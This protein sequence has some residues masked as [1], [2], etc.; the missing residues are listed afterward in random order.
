MSTA[1]DE[2]CA[3][4]ERATE[5]T[6]YRIERTAEGFDLRIAVDDARWHGL[7]ASAGRR[8]VVE[9]QV[10]LDGD[11]RTLQITDAQ[12]HVRWAVGVTGRT[13]HLVAAQAG[14]VRGRTWS[15]SREWTWRPGQRPQAKPVV[16]DRLSTAE[17]R[18]LIRKA[19]IALGWTERMGPYERAGLIAVGVGLLTCLAV[20]LLLLIGR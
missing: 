14:A 17:A 12:F 18:R 19:A 7:L 11:A 15:T 13:P 6:P 1:A 20:A 8:R 16:E 2:L 9:C 3:A 10:R 4:V 5:G